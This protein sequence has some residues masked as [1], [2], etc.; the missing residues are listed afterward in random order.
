MPKRKPPITAA[1]ERR[2]LALINAEI[3]QAELNALK[4]E[5][6]KLYLN[7]NLR[8]TRKRRPGYS[9]P[10]NPERDMSATDRQTGMSKARQK[11]MESPLV[12]G[13]VQTLVDNIVGCGFK[14]NMKTGNDVYDKEVEGRWELRKDKLDIR[15]MRPWFKLQ[16]MWQFRKTIDGDVGVHLVD[17][18]IAEASE[19]EM[20][21]GTDGES[22]TLSYLQT[23]EAD[24]IYKETTATDEGV[25]FDANGRPTKYFVSKR[26]KADIELGSSKDGNKPQTIPAS[27]FILYANYPHER[28]ERKRGIS[29]LLQNLNIFED[30]E[31]IL[32]AM[33]QKVKNEAF[34][35]IKF[36][37]EIGPD[38]SLFGTEATSDKTAEDG[39]TRKTVKM[40]PGLNLNLSPGEDADV[41]ESK[42][43]PG[44]FIAFYRMMLR[45][46]GTRFGLPLEMMLFDFADTNYSGGRALLELAKKR[47]KVEQEEMKGLCDRIFHWWLAREIKYNGLIV[48]GDVRGWHWTHRWGMPGWPYLDP[49]KSATANTIDLANATTSRTRILDDEGYGDF[50]ELVET[51]RK[52]QDMLNAAGIAVSIGQPGQKI[53]G[54]QQ[55]KDE[56]VEDEGEA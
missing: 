18:G 39:V 55:D 20:Q 13:M 4:N 35:G 10:G 9:I 41:M 42:S 38:G 46:A 48:P 25:E 51:L 36:K 30:L 53:S 24:R 32:D 27:Q 33:C 8:N 31:E 16:R 37:T 12:M 43:P 26:A 14:L 56:D 5:R 2:D 49:V 15:G 40:V 1:K 19:A 11:C 29:M 45:Y 34:M 17:G 54:D 47:F 44:E 7:D 6:Y 22:Y 3:S 50:E 28:A 52:E 21:V 23:I